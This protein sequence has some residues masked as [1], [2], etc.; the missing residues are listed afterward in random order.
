MYLTEHFSFEELTASDTAVRLGIANQPDYH[1]LGNLHILARGLERV[2]VILNVPIVISSGYRSPALNAAI[3][4]SKNSAHMTGL[5]AD[6]RAPRFGTPADVARELQ[7]E[8]ESVGF[9]QMILEF[10]HWV[11]ISFHDPS[12]PVR[13]QVLTAVNGAD[14]VMYL[15]GLLAV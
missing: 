2:R 5:A 13:G 4:G 12:E 3:R 10:G 11:H 7:S 8:K 6:F 1:T 9:D 15:N 14:G